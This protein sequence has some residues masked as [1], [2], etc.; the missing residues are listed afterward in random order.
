MTFSTSAFS[1]VNS[2]VTVFVAASTFSRFPDWPNG[3]HSISG[4]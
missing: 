2:V 4:P 3:T 1:S